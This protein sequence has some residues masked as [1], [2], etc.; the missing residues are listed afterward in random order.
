MGE[1]KETVWSWLDEHLE[2]S[3]LIVLLLVITL[4]AGLQVVMRKVFSSPLSWSEELCRYCFMWS[5]FMGIAYCIR[6][7]CEIHINT[8]LNLFEGK[9]RLLMVLTGE[10][11]CLFMY[12]AFFYATAVIVRKAMASQQLSPAIGIPNYVIYSGALLAFALA[13]LR[14]VQNLIKSLRSATACSDGKS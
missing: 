11:I 10:S 14:Q 4:L 5:G 2:E 3:I 8:F 1:R 6:H 9:K 7:R 13:I 12:G